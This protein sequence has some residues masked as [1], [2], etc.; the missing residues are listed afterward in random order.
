MLL[1]KVQNLPTTHFVRDLSCAT[2]VSS[3]SYICIKASLQAADW[4]QTMLEFAQT[5]IFI[6]VTTEVTQGYS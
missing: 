5:A 4:E 2:S 3:G 1:Q 6:M